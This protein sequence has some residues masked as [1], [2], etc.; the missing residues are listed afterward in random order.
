MNKLSSPAPPVSNRHQS[1]LGL[2][3]II[4]SSLLAGSG[5]IIWKI[6]IL[7]AGGDYFALF[8][9]PIFFLGIVIYSFATLFMILAFKKGDLSV[10]FP[11]LATS[12]IWV[13][14]FAWK[15]FENEEITLSR[16]IGIGFV[17]VGCSLLGLQQ[18]VNTRRYKRSQSDLPKTKN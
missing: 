2:L 14:L 16:A 6:T 13:N 9:K 12:Y 4:I 5:Q 3:F 18:N 15:L 1:H 11:V 7:Q 17:F 10:L 8:L